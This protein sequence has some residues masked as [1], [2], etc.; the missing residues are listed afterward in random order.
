MRR[1]IERRF[2]P[3]PSWAEQKLSERSLEEINDLGIRVLD[4]VDLEDLLR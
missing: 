1:Q 3:L 4:M 2:G